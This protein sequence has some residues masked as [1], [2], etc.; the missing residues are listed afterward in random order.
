MKKFLAVL[1]TLA[2]MMT[3]VSALAASANLNGKTDTTVEDNDEFAIWIDEGKADIANAEIDKLN[4]SSV[5]EYFGKADE[6]AAILGEGEYAVNEFAGVGASNADAI[7]GDSITV[8]LAFASDYA[9]GDTVAVLMG[10]VDGENIDWNVF[11]GTIVNGAVQFDLS[12]EVAAAAEA[13][14][15]LIAIVSK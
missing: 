7:E 10:V 2:L 9:E 4:A 6:I 12:A 11:P 13:G 3:A 8:S 5:A 14:T 1:L 15:V